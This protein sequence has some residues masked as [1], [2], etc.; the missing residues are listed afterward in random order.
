MNGYLSSTYL[1]TRDITQHTVIMKRDSCIFLL[2]E[3]EIG[4]CVFVC[5][6]MEVYLCT[7]IALVTATKYPVLVHTI[8]PTYTCK[9]TIT[10]QKS[11][12]PLN[13]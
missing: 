3:C 7:P 13:N 4:G 1:P 9:V 5:I 2:I 6:N 10:L 11:Y 8:T 12:F